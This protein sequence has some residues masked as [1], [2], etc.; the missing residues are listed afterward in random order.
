[1]ILSFSSDDCGIRTNLFDGEL[2]VRASLRTEIYDEI[3][4]ENTTK[5]HLLSL[6]RND[7]YEFFKINGH[8]AWGYEPDIYPGRV[9]FTGDNVNMF[10]TLQ[11]NHTLDDLKEIAESFR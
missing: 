3:K 9:S 10:Y 11:G 8:F 2:E 4:F 5:S 1:L 7:H 6:P